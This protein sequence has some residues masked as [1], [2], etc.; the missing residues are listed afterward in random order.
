MNLGGVPNVREA[1][2]E[3]YLRGRSDLRTG[4]VLGAMV[5]ALILFSGAAPTPFIYFQF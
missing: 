1:A 5:A 2:A 4:V 3:S